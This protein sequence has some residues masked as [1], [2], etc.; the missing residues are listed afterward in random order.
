MA[1]DILEFSGKYCFLS[2]F[3]ESPIV[4]MGQNY[5]TAEHLYQAMKA[6]MNSDH[7]LIRKAETAGKAKKLGKKVLLRLDWQ[8]VK[9]DNMRVVVDL[10]FEQNPEL[11]AALKA[12]GEVELQEGNWWGDKYW[13]VDRKTGEGLN[14]L[15]KILMEQ[16]ERL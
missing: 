4:F 6:Q 5:P 8:E 11:A 13:G 1:D 12:T 15:G 2:N 10:K 16:R 7:E 3:A 14:K 9:D